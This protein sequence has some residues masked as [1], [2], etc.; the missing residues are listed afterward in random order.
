MKI[1]D[2]TSIFNFPDYIDYI[3]QK[4]LQDLRYNRILPEKNL[5]IHPL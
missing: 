1:F 5:I 2:Q 4:Q 3:E